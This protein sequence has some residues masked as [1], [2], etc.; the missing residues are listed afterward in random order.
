MI[1]INN[2]ERK[3]LKDVEDQ[4]NLIKKVLLKIKNSLNDHNEDFNNKG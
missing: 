4:K 2:S 1:D 3:K